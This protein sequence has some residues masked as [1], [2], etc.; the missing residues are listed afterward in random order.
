MNFKETFVLNRGNV[1]Q[2]NQW[3]PL[4]W[5]LLLNTKKY[6]QEISGF[7]MVCGCGL[8]MQMGP[9]GRADIPCLSLHASVKGCLGNCSGQWKACMVMC[10]TSCWSLK[11]SLYFNTIFFPLCHKASIVSD[12]GSIGWDHE[13]MSTW[14]SKRANF[15]WICSISGFKPLRFG[16]C[17]LL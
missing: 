15:P 12:S 8:V 14:R 6:I 2:T 17:L 11:T 7:E 10:V 1:L 4:I 16:G 5:K 3:G 9:G 13:I